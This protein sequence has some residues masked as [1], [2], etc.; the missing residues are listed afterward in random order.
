M[1]IKQFNVTLDEKVVKRAMEIAY[2]RGAKLSPIINILLKD[3]IKKNE[4]E[5]GNN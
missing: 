3:W 2:G 1:V 4:E 5:N